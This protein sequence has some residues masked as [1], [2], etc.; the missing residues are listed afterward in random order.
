MERHPTPSETE[1]ARLTAEL[2]V[3][4]AELAW[5]RVCHRALYSFWDRTTDAFDIELELDDPEMI[6][7]FE[8]ATPVLPTATAANM[9]REVGAARV[10]ELIDS[11]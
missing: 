5:W 1:I 4:R 6:E 8:T 3:A 2:K 9:C 10:A 11:L 7:G